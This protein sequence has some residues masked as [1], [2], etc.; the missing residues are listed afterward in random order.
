VPSVAETAYPRLKSHFT[1]KE[2]QEIYTPTREDVKFALTQTR[3]T[4]TRP[5]FLILLKTFQRLGYFIPLQSVP[6]P[7]IKHICEQ[8]K[9]SVAPRTLAKYDASRAKWR[10]TI[11][12]REY[13]KIEPYG[14]EARRLIVSS[15]AQAAITKHSISRCQG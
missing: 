14:V 9:L 10:H 7:L 1:V 11:A 8:M 13:L 2:L 5:C 6:Q 15:I 3:T 12:I 4:D